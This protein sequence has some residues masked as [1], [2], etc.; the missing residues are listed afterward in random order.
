MEERRYE[1][2][3]EDG[4]QSTECYKTILGW[5]DLWRSRGTLDDHHNSV[6]ARRLLRLA[7]SYSRCAYTKTGILTVK[8]KI[9]VS[10]GKVEEAERDYKELCEILK[11][12]PEYETFREFKKAISEVRSL[13]AP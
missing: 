5:N 2:P 4:G 7:E 8:I 12:A 9:A 10:E 6:K 13:M 3:K 11:S 1:S